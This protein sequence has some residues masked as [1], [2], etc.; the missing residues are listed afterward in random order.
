[1]YKM[2]MNW[3]EEREREMDVMRFRLT[4]CVVVIVS[5]MHGSGCMGEGVS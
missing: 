4:V 1:M 3:G 2:L 5:C